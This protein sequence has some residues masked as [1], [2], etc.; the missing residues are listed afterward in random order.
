MNVCK[1]AERDELRGPEWPPSVEDTNALLDYIDKLEA[2]N[3][4][5]C[6]DAFNEGSSVAWVQAMAE[7]KDRINE[8]EAENKRLTK[9]YR[10]VSER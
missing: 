5:D 2:G 8:L 4:D 3:A 10:E 7:C 1:K 9:A 6:A